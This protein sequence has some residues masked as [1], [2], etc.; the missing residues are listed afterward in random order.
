MKLKPN[1]V[2]VFCSVKGF[3][4]F[5]PNLDLVN[6]VTTTAYVQ[7]PSP[8]TSAGHTSWVEEEPIDGGVREMLAFVW[9]TALSFPRATHAF[10]SK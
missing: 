6:T 8:F 5:L 10:F 9:N 4:G 2:L 3:G 7:D 1:H